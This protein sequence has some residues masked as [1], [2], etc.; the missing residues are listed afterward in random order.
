MNQ[1]LNKV[2]LKIMLRVGFWNSRI[3]LE[4]MIQL[5]HNRFTRPLLATTPIT[6]RFLFSRAVYISRHAVV[7][8]VSETARAVLKGRVAYNIWYTM[9]V[10]NVYIYIYIYITYKMQYI[11]GYICATCLIKSAL[12]LATTAPPTGTMKFLSVDWTN[13]ST[14]PTLIASFII[15][16]HLDAWTPYALLTIWGIPY[17]E[18]ILATSINLQLYNK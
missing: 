9:L 2:H 1:R 12:E 3:S 7:D 4:V 11:P 6:L 17:L 16:I 5:H 18:H 14:R 8:W 10:I 13:A 15:F